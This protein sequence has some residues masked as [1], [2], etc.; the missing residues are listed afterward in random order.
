MVA[1]DAD[2]GNIDYYSRDL[3]QNVR[4]TLLHKRP[5]SLG[6][7]LIAHADLPVLLTGDFGPNVA[8]DYEKP[9]FMETHPHKEAFRDAFIAKFA[10]HLD[11]Q[12]MHTLRKM[13]HFH[14]LE[15]AD[16]EIDNKSFWRKFTRS[17]GNFRSQ[18]SLP[19][20]I[21]HQIESDTE[22]ADCL[23]R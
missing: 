10:R 13:M 18:I 6:F 21:A 3:P 12:E 5:L 7:N 4:L 15:L 16:M 22:T 8:I 20:T 11:T 19:E 17:I 1:Y 9:F 23:Q 2:R 14:T